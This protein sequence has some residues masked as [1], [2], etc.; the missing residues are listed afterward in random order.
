MAL[1]NILGKEGEAYALNDL[2]QKGYIILDTNW[3]CGKLELDIVARTQDELIVF[4]VKTRSNDSFI[5]P[6]DSITPKKINNTVRAAH[7]YIVGHKLNLAVRFDI[8]ILIT[9]EQSFSIEHIED[10]F[11]PPLNGGR[12]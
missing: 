11:Y 8:L 12:R 9:V 4:E 7:A 1:H 2:K 6:L 3:R 5:D 10:A